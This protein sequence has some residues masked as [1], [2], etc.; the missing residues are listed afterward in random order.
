MDIF[1]YITLFLISY[2]LALF[3]LKY[4]GCWKK[5]EC[6]GYTNCCPNCNKPLERIKRGNVDYFINYLTFQIF[7]FKRYKCLSCNW[8]GLKWERPFS[9]NS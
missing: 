9:P 6:N 5:Q 1:L 2:V 4:S 3:I 7:D 8:K